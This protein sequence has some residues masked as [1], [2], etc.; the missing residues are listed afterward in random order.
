[1]CAENPLWGAPRI[2]GELLKLGFTV[3]QST[4][5]K[6]MLRGRKPPSQGWKTFLQNHA[7][8]IAA[9]DFLVVPTLTF[10]RLFAFIVLGI[11]RRNI[12]WIGI[13]TNP[14]A[15]W[16][17]NQITEA[18]PWDTAPEYLI[19][20][21]DG[22]YGEVF[23]RRLRAMGIR[24]RPISPRSPWQNGY[25]ERVIGSIRR[26]CLDHVIVW[27]EAHLGRVL[28][29]YAAYYNSVRT[30]LGLRK[31]APHCRP[32]ERRGRIVTR[33]FLGGLH[34]QYCRI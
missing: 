29:S 2:H 34:H 24:D 19:R 12:L 21:N 17:A 27:S 22:A 8:G 15:E 23:T 18:F 33:D 3:A 1:M 4:V 11:G 9:I 26:E 7:D 16:L 20:D 14:T 5:S 6:Y 30:H 13:T 31:D 10:E 25:V 28:T 32:I